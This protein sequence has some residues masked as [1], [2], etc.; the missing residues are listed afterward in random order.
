M[1]AKRDLSIPI[2]V[3]GVGRQASGRR[4]QNGSKSPV[5][6]PWHKTGLH[7]DWGISITNLL[8]ATAWEKFAKS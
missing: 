2:W 5:I 6:A 7:G 4:V 8:V 1:V 3:A